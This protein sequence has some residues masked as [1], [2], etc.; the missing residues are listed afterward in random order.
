MGSRMAV[1]ARAKR[2]R[3]CQAV[4]DG[5]EPGDGLQAVGAVIS[6]PGA[7]SVI[8]RAVEHASRPAG[9]LRHPEL[10]LHLGPNGSRGRAPGARQKCFTSQPRDTPWAAPTADRHLSPERT[11]A[12]VGPAI[13]R[14]GYS[15]RLLHNGPDTV[16]ATVAPSLAAPGLSID[17]SPWLKHPEISAGAASL[18]G[19]EPDNWCATSSNNSRTIL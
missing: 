5:A 16:G 12:T 18:R 7:S 8:R 17:R 10:N 15:A 13:G 3:G 11:W 2:G 14:G 1:A 9:C 6:P 19:N 4:P